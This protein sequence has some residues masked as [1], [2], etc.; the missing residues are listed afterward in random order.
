MVDGLCYSWELIKDSLESGRTFLRQKAVFS[1]NRWAIH[2]ELSKE[3]QVK[4][5]LERVDCLLSK[6][7]YRENIS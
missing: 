5:V 4:K 3:Y 7:A 6:G 1:S 2:E